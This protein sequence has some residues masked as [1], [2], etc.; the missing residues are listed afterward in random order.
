MGAIL[1]RHFMKLPS[2]N[3]QWILT[4]DGSHTLHSELFG[5][6]CH[7][8]SGA[9]TE[10]LLHYLE[11][12]HV[13][14]RLRSYPQFQILEVGFGLGIG[15]LTTLDVLRVE[16]PWHF[17]SLEI[18]PDLVKWFL[19]E[20][21]HLPIVKNAKWTSEKIVHSQFENIELTILIGDARRELAPFL[22]DSTL[23]FHAIFQDAFSPKRNPHL[24]TVEWFSLLKKHSHQE[25]ILS[26]YSASSSIRKSLIHSGWVIKKGHKFGPKRSST[27]AMLVGE[28]DQEILTHLERSPVHPLFDKGI[29]DFLK[30]RKD[31]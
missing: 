22:K 27:R 2:Q 6:T 10:T 1:N 21:Q 28:S 29:E 5:E 13:K 24:W 19:E 20:Y 30:A 15:L 18:D 12:C 23:K 3:Y 16:H 31:G 4:E 11:G 8:T 9:K 7:S 25:C 14:E 17:V 26:T